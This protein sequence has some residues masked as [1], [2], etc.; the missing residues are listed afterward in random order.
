MLKKEYE[1]LRD[2]NVW[3]IVPIPDNTKLHDYLVLP[4]T[5]CDLSGKKIKDK[6]RL[7]LRGDR[8]RKG[9]DYD[10]SFSPTCRIES[11]RFMM[12]LTAATRRKLFQADIVQAYVEAD[13]D[14]QIFTRFP[15]HWKL[16]FNE[17]I[18]DNHCLLSVKALYGGKQSGRC[19]YQDFRPKIIKYGLMVS[20]NDNCLFYNENMILIIYVDDILISCLISSIPPYL[21]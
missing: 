10:E 8:F 17:D 13:F 1:G 7:V 3:Q 14:K 4:S 6:V 19:W 21:I 2:R 15:P 20:M 5:K 11:V 9:I 12:S 18:P 16:V